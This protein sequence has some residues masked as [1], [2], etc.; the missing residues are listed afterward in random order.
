MVG[1]P[2]VRVV[3]T[4]STPGQAGS[5][6]FSEATFHVMIKQAGQGN[7]YDVVCTPVM[8]LVFIYAV[9]SL[10]LGTSVGWNRKSVSN[11]RLRPF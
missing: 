6:S 11:F 3:C 8:G 10:H 1:I 7:L 5:S 2:R 4:P 9:L